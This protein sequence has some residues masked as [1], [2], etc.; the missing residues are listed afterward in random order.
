MLLHDTALIYGRY[1]RQSLR[2]RFALLFGVLMPLLY[3]LFFGPLLTDLPLGGRGSSWQVLVPGLLLQLGLFGASFAGFAVI[4]EKGQGV[5]E[6]MRVTPVSR[7][8]L[9]LGRVLRDATVFVFQAV[10]L[11]L[12]A[13]VMGLRA[14]LPGVLIGFAFVA[15][16]TVSL[17]SLSYA[18]AMKVDS[19][20]EFGPAVNAMTMPMMLLSGLMLPMTLGPRWLDVLS[21]FTP[22]RY[23]VDAVRD[24]YVGSY[25]TAHMLYGALVAV[26]FAALAVT[27][28]TRVF[29]TAGA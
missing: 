15:L 23:L 7:L 10:L 4:I 12:A 13:L 9:L 17:A 26:A 24:A 28:G 16:L 29:R 18:L 19:P 8:A 2:S 5:V 21:H 22:F 14:P 25:T 20:A 27:V 6:R 1:L 11:V 3:L